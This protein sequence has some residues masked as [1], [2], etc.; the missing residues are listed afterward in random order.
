MDGTVSTQA[1]LLGKEY[2]DHLPL[3]ASFGRK[4]Q[5]GGKLADYEK[6]KILGEGKFGRVYKALCKTS[7]VEVALKEHFPQN[8]AKGPPSGWV[9]SR[10]FCRPVEESESFDLVRVSQIASQV[11][12]EVVILKSLWHPNVARLLDVFTEPG[13]LE[14]CTLIGHACKED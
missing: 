4:F 11:I 13:E 7:H 9:S 14:I 10:S 12:R 2:A 6:T 1:L 5:G 3:A 8:E